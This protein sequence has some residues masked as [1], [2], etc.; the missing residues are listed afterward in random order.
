MHRYLALIWNP[1]DSSADQ[2][3]ASTEASLLAASPWG[4]AYRN[5]GVAV[6][7]Q[8][9][10]LQSRHIRHLTD[11]H[12]LVLG[13]LFRRTTQT[14]HSP[15]ADTRF[16]ASETRRIVESKGHHLVKNYWGSYLAIVRDATAGSYSIFR[17]PTA[18]LPCYHVRWGNVHVFFSDIE[19]FK[20]F[21]PMDLSVNWPQIAATLLASS[22]LSRQCSLSEV[23]DL[24]GGESITISGDSERRTILWHPGQF[25]REDGLNDERT[26]AAALRSTVSNVVHT[27]ASEHTA[28]LVRLSGGL[29]SSIVTSCLAER[30]DRPEMTCLNFYIENDHDDEWKGPM[31]GGYSRENLAKLRRIVG[32]ADERQF[33]RSVAEKCSLRLVERA[34]RVSDLDLRR[35]WKA[36]LVPRPAN[37]IYVIDEDDAEIRYAS[38]CEATACFTGEGGDTVF[39]CTQR[40]IG[41]LDYA[42]LHPLG[43][44]LFRHIR[45]T[46]GLSGES[47]PRVLSKILRHGIL[48]TR[49][50]PPFEP[51]KRPHL[52][53]DDA[54]AAAHA[55]LLSHPWVETVPRLCPGKHNHVIGVATS[56][57]NYQYVHHRERFA[58]SVHPLA[59]QPVVETCL[60]IPTYVL[61]VDGVSRGLARR[62]FRDLLPPAVARRTVKGL[63]ISFWQHLVRSNIAYIRECLLDGYLVRQGLLDRNK[64]NDYL[65]QDQPFL[66]VHPQQ[67]MDYLGCEAWLGQWLSK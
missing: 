57:P 42:Y 23:E 63:P 46:A 29:D 26:A 62:A 18:T 41:A 51:M 22:Y 60:R 49:L 28:I 33:A 34:R 2:R 20:R 59:S 7:Y 6:M 40:V 37:Y 15:A 56:V 58:T 17:D 13:S 4:V 21:V 44:A 45:L 50:P 65:I 5:G 16:D 3:A 35:I 24:P 53:R 48:R 43:G 36:P 25:C 14:S 27:L 67:I 47:V 9:S 19:D 64:L 10:H 30:E 38:E 8:P 52:L 66:T 11:L 12:G 1:A 55:S 31:P 54:A 39:Y 32:S 61:L